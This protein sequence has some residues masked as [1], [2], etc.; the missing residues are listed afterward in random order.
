MALCL[1]CNPFCHGC[2]MSFVIFNLVFLLFSSQGIK[3]NLHIALIMDCKN[4]LF[5]V[6]C[7]SNPAFYKSCVVQ[8]MEEWSKESMKEVRDF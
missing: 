3:K 5:A 2:T 4:P 6:N 1:S 7:Q 8:W